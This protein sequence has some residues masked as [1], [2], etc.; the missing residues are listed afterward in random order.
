M[1]IRLTSGLHRAA[2]LRPDAV[3]YR[4]DGLPT[5]W[6][7]LIER[8]SRAASGLRALGMQPGD[9]VVVL[10]ENNRAFYELYMVAPW[11]DVILASLNTRWAVPE[12]IAALN[13]ADADV[14]VVDKRFAPLVPQFKA[15]RPT[16]RHIIH[17]EESG[18]PGMIGWEELIANNSLLPDAE[19]AQHEVAYL[20]YTSGTTGTPKG[21]ML[22]VEN[23]FM[24]ALMVVGEFGWTDESVFIVCMPL[25]HVGASSPLLTQILQGSCVTLL[26]K[27]DPLAVLETISRDRVTHAQLVPTMI[28][29]VIDHPAVDEYDLTSMVRFFYGASAMPPSLIAKALEKFP[30]AQFQQG[31]ALTETA[32]VATSLRP[33]DHHSK[34]V[35]SVGRAV[36]GAEIRVVDPQGV[37][38]PRG[39]TGEILIRSPAVMAGYWRKPQET[40]QALRNGW[41]HTG[42]SGYLNE[43]GYLYVVDRI[44]DMIISGGENVYS[45]EVENAVYRHP[46][47]SECAAIGLPDSLWGE[48]VA[49][50]VQLRAGAAATEAEIIDTARQY[51][52]G[53]KVPRRV[54]FSAAP[55]P[56]NA[57]GK[58][59]K[60]ALKERY[61]G[62]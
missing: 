61:R 30:F 57:S 50:V 3:A 43:E 29:M 24:S 8:V 27:F 14:L 42:D 23:A 32:A 20:F 21:V 6:G 1:T 10:S 16:L 62:G 52:G 15:A 12:M 33:A 58:I 54:L 51:L 41:L 49:I 56:K 17:A 2:A 35:T 4:F 60:F 37:D 38:V 36:P 22:T 26:P 31:Y 44:K 18:V 11:A 45:V 47:V 39:T 40:A 46:A 34:F 9:R 53:Y 48:I 28:R 19:R 5:T 13:D 55:L 7:R 25:F 59:T